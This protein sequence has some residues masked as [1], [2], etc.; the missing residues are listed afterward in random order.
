IPAER[1]AVYARVAATLQRLPGATVAVLADGLAANG[2]EAAFKTLLEKNATRLIWATSDRVSLTGLTGAD[3]QV[4]GFTL[5]AI[6]APGD[7]A[8]A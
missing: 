4:D 8:P 5:T 7:P 6:R 3:N 1:P 2:D